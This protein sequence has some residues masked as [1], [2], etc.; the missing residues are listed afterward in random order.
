M[1]KFLRVTINF[2][3][4]F[5][6]F[7][8]NLSKIFL[9]FKKIRSAEIIIFQN[10]RIGFGNIFTSLDLA[11]KMFKKKIL[12]I[13]FF[14]VT[15]FHNDKL[16]MM[17][18][19]DSIILRT[20]IYNSLRNSRYGEYDIYPKKNLKITQ[21]LL[22]QVIKKLR[23]KHCLDYDIPSLY[24]FSE[25]KSETLK[26]KKHN[27]LFKSHKWMNYYYHLV[28]QNPSLKINKKYCLI[29]KLILKQKKKTICIYIRR[30]GLINE[31]TKN[32]EFYEQAIKYFIKKKY[33]IY[34]VGEY[35]DLL[36]KYPKF[37]KNIELPETNFKPNKDL[38][39]A[40]QLVSNYY[41]GDSG[42]G[43][44]FAMY[45][46]HSVLIGSSEKFYM[47]NVKHFKNKIFFKGKQIYEKSKIYKKLNELMLK[48][49]IFASPSFLYKHNFSIKCEDNLKIMNYIKKNF[50]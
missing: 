17:L 47:P 38:S 11:Q 16:F 44:W 7:F 39:L 21:H 9:Y 14:D 19:A 10:Q 4:L 49:S 28:D 31:Y 13:N 27:I 34:L 25:K 29:N 30:D 42:G 48:N 45:K 6:L 24:K 33:T 1:S 37:K 46:K 8:F 3:V 15:K 5:F 22:I 26:S 32:Y 12:F 23:K 50:K 18:N 36:K 2:I 41:L 43:S 40:M 35:N 20:S